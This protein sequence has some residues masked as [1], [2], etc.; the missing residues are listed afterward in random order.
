MKTFSS[1]KPDELAG[2]IGG[3]LADIQTTAVEA[4]Q[5][6]VDKVGKEAVE[7]IKAASPTPS[8]GPAKYR[9]GWRYKKVKVNSDG[10]FSTVVYNAT[11]GWLTQL[12]EKGHP[13]ISKGEVV[14][15]AAA[16]PHIAP[17]SEWMQTQGVQIITD[18]I[19]KEIQNLK[20]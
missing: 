19:Q 15:R 7:K 10:S 1:Q 18:E 8:H 11:H 5:A 16:F 13:I 9:A 6:G 3:V 20:N 12:L 4:V 14:G 2:Y 17:V